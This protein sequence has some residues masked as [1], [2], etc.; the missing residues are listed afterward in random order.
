MCDPA[1]LLF[2]QD[3]KK[4]GQLVYHVN[5]LT[6]LGNKRGKILLNEGLYSTV[7]NQRAID[8][9]STESVFVRLNVADF[10]YPLIRTGLISMKLW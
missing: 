8:L 7:I 10:I 9:Q 6:T 1:H 2:L 3:K 5:V 4:A